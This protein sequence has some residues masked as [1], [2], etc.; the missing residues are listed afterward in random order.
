MILKLE[1]CGW[2]TGTTDI[3]KKWEQL[4]NIVVNL[5]ASARG[6]PAFGM[7]AT[8]GIG[9]SIAPVATLVMGER[10]RLTTD[11]PGSNGGPCLS[12]Q[13]G[14]SAHVQVGISQLGAVQAWR[15]TIGGGV[16]LGTTANGMVG[17]GTYHYIEA[18]VNVHDS[19][20]TVHVRLNGVEVLALTAQ[21]TRNAGATGLIDNMRFFA[22]SNGSHAHDFYVCDTNAP[23]G[24]FLGDVRVDYLAVNAAGANTTWTPSAGSNFQNVDDTDP[25]DDSTYNE[26]DVANEKDSYQH[27]ALTSLVVEDIKGIVMQCFA[28]KSDAG[29]R[30]MR[31]G[32]KSGATESVNAFTALPTSYGYRQRAFDVDPNT[33]AAWTKAN[34]DAVE[35]L[36]ECGNP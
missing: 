15:N 31:E 14:A 29:T 22:V 25:D 6:G 20:G 2:L 35:S 32:I 12:F 28:R 5:S 16:L 8:G 27:A 23:N 4:N 19:T 33:A 1:S 21:D 13:E 26:T 30:T 34:V 17:V 11:M 7:S 18:K 10:F 36:V 9:T 24:D 3:A